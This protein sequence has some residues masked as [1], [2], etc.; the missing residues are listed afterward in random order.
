VLLE[1]ARWSQSA[2]LANTERDANRFLR[3]D[4]L[5]APSHMVL[6]LHHTMLGRR[7]DAA[8][9]L[10][11]ALEMSAAPPLRMMAGWALAETGHHEEGTQVLEELEAGLADDP[12]RPL[13]GFLASA[14]RG[15]EARA[16]SH[17]T[18]EALRRFATTEWDYLILAGGHAL[19]GRN[20]DAV[21][22]LRRAV[23]YGQVNYPFMS[24]QSSFF[25]PLRGEPDFQALMA[26]VKPRW[27]ALRAWQRGLEG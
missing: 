6:G 1:W 11:R 7:E 19:L 4:P 23:E 5:F 24:E 27:E 2:G 10:R 20:R 12:H 22:S 26:E 3:L 15:D 18:P 13:V 17:L 14:L 8:P 9:S 21:S 25:E 16:L